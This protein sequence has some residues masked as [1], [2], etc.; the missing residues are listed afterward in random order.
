MAE[1]KVSVIVPVYN[2]EKYLHK[3]L[4]SIIN[5]TYRNLEIILVDDGSPDN[6]GA[7]CD[8]YAQKDSRIKVIHQKNGGLSAARNTGLDCAV[9]EYISFVD[10]DDW[11]SEEFIEQLISSAKPNSLVMC[12]FIS[13]ES[14]ADGSIPVAGDRIETIDQNE[15]WSRTIG[16]KCIL[17]TVAWNKLYPK[18]IF[19]ELRFQT[20]LLHEDEAILH[21]VIDQ[22]DSINVLHRPM[23]FYRRTRSSI[24]GRGF[25]PSRLDLFVGLAE[26]LKYFRDKKLPELENALSERYWENYKNQI[27]AVNPAEDPDG[28]RARAIRNYRI[29]FPSLIRAK[30]IRTSQKISIIAMRISPKTFQSMW[31]IIGVFTR[32]RN[33]DQ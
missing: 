23:Y 6:C 9:G 16:E 12:D 3:C 20:G 27:F 25:N 30:S 5:Q 8:E 24:M 1:E 22:V 18:R 21:Y 17:Y 26:R 14:D 33:V 13:W 29:A 31:R 7:I 32:Q 15:F 11:V 2:V 4:D 19:S 10:S 28:H